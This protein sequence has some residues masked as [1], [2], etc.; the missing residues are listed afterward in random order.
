[1]AYTFND[2]AA[3][4]VGESMARAMWEGYELWKSGCELW[5]E[6]LAELPSARTPEA[7]MDVNTRFLARSLNAPGFASG[8][9]MKDQG[10]TQP[11]LND[12]C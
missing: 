9:L 5:L 8:E 10:L 3:T 11:V 6:Y 1:M 4:A 2:A 7:L 12:E